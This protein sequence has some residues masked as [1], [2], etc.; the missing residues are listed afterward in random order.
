MS[1][2]LI[3]WQRARQLVIDELVGDLAARAPRAPIVT[4]TL[5]AAQGRVLA[6]AVWVD[7]DLP[8]FHRATRDGFAVRAA[9][10]RQA[11][12]VLAIGGEARAGVAWASAMC[13]GT[14]IEIA[15]GA[16]LPDGADAV[17]M[18]EHVVRLGDGTVRLERSAMPGENVVPRG[19][20]ACAGDVALACGT[21]LGPAQL[22]LLASV[23]CAAPRVFARPRVAVLATGDELVPVEAVPGAA[24][25][26]NSNAVQLAAQVACAGGEPVLLPAAPDEPRAL[27]LALEQAAACA[28]QIV[29]AGGV[30]MGR[31]DLVGEVL[32]ELGATFCFAG[33]ALRPGKPAAFGRVLGRP[34][35]ALPGNP[36]SCLVTFEFFARP[37]IE[38]ASGATPTPLLL[39]RATLAEPLAAPLLP[40]AQ[41]LPAALVDGNDDGAG[42]SGVRVRAIPTH[43]SGDLAALA[44]AQLW[45]LLPPGC[46]PLAA[47]DE[48]AVLPR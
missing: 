9:D 14:T 25:I 46:G 3:S 30:S 8:P 4:V 29:I 5:A 11:G 40:L 35:F 21:R 16:P 43:G 47:G 20:E 28:D 15:T 23:G 31:Y 12:V 34:F 24:Q 32:A 26:R 36:L 48:V 27:K 2:G 41:V 7:R 38:L 33:V 39:A 37:A 19:S 13:A 18:I 10:A 17:V 1:L 44:R 42:D 45:L 6:E 22:A